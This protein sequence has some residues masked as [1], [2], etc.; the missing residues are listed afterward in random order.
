VPG[1][2]HT[3]ARDAPSQSSLAIS[4]RRCVSEGYEELDIMLVA[5]WPTRPLHGS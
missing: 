3:I 4:T 5:A 1:V 2:I